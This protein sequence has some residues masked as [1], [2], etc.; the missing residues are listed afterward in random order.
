MSDPKVL[1]SHA[2]LELHSWKRSPRRI[3][4]HLLNSFDVAFFPVFLFFFHSYFGTPTVYYAQEEL[5]RPSLELHGAGSRWGRQ[6]PSDN[7]HKEGHVHT[8]G[9]LCQGVTGLPA[10]GTGFI[11]GLARKGFPEGV[12]L[13]PGPKDNQV[14]N[15]FTSQSL[16]FLACK[17]G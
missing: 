15:H 16:N 13:A 3:C 11:G 17:M 4:F 12:T 8:L 5:G 9:G 10:A 14:K 2:I 1:F 6:K 7:W